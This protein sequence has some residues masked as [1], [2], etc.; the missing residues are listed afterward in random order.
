LSRS[1]LISIYRFQ[2]HA[3]SAAD[4][5]WAADIVIIAER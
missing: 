2:C 4:I 3:V 5:G 1:F